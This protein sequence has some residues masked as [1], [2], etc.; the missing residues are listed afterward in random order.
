MEATAP[1]KNTI[2]GVVNLDIKDFPDGNTV[3][4]YPSSKNILLLLIS[5]VMMFVPGC[6]SWAST[7]GHN[8]SS[9][10]GIIIAVS[11]VLTVWAFWYRFGTSYGKVI[12]RRREGLVLSSG[13]IPFED[14]ADIMRNI[15]PNPRHAVE[16]HIKFKDGQQV[17][18]ASVRNTNVALALTDAISKMNR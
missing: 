3:I 2:K 5:C 12:V 6:V 18:L 8:S 1:M 14:V 17:H 13:T 16:M 10:A 11:I 4:T 15:P 9:S 7:L